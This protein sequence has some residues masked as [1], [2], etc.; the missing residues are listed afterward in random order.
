MRRLYDA[1]VREEYLR[2]GESSRAVVEGVARTARV[3]T[4]AAAIVVVVF[5]AFVFS[6]EVFLKLTDVAMAAAIPLDATVVR[7]VLVPATMQ[8]LGRTTWRMLRW[9]DRL[10]PRLDVEP[11]PALTELSSPTSTVAGRSTRETRP[12]HP[13]SRRF[14]AFGCGIRGSCDGLHHGRVGDAR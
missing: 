6:T 13:R 10:L 14:P 3:I 2:H 11:R 9:L 1:R 4:V 5:L 12:P 8:L 7:M